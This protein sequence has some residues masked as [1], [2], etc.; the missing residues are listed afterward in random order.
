MMSLTAPIGLLYALFAVV[1]SAVNL[2]SQWVVL[3]G[4][5]MLGFRWGTS[6]G[7]ALIVGTG[8][9][10]IVK[11]LLDKHHIFE[12]RSR[13]LFAH[14]KRFSLYTMTGV[15][16]TAVFWIIE[17]LTALID[18]TGDLIYL[19]G[20][21]GLAIGYTIKYYLDRRYVFTP[22]AATERWP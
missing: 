19:G 22:A 5:P 7:L 16:T 4:A 12:D 21:I 13:G 15:L 17:L 20:A 2:A 9:G 3:N 10:L 14:A 18:P 1:A 11:Y 6:L 8:A